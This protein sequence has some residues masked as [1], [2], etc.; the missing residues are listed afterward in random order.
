MLSYE[1]AVNQLLKRYATSAAT[2]KEDEQGST[3][4]QEWLTQWDFYQN[5]WGLSQRWGDVHHEQTLRDFLLR[6]ST[7]A[8]ATSCADGR[9]IAEKQR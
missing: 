1:G 3:F 9:R 4:K 7:L 2:A 8:S 6:S 5:S